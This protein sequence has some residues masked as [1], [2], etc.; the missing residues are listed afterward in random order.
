MKIQ[1]L[2]RKLKE[3]VESGDWIVVLTK[4]ESAVRFKKKNSN[5][6]YCPLTCIAK[7]KT[8]I[9]YKTKDV[10]DAA[11]K[12]QYTDLVTYITEASDKK[13]INIQYRESIPFRKWLF[14]TFDLPKDKL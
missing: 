4:K 11:I 14:R 2:Q 7:E 13:I 10:Y 5:F 12:I 6:S 8:G 1:G 9:S 3:L